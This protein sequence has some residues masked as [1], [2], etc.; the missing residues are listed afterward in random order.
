MSKFVILISHSLS[1]F[2]VWYVQGH[3]SITGYCNLPSVSYYIAPL[4]MAVYRSV[5]LLHIEHFLVVSFLSPYWR[6][7]KYGPPVLNF[8]GVIDALPVIL[9]HISA[10]GIV[11]QHLGFNILHRFCL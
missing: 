11:K 5:W 9:H 10:Y 1:L 6:Y 3:A 2:G 4:Y 7:P 8:S